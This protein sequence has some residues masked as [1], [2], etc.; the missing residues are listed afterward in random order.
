MQSMQGMLS[1]PF[2]DVWGNEGKGD[3]K[4]IANV[5]KMDGNFMESCWSMQGALSVPVRE[6][7]GN[8]GK[9]GEMCR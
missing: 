3:W 8:V 2:R 9:C 6:M 5:W 1:T 4:W 7:W